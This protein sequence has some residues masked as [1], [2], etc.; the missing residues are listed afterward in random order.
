MKPL[1]RAPA[2][3]VL[4]PLLEVQAFV[5][6]A[7]RLALVGVAHGGVK[8]VG[9]EPPNGPNEPPDVEVGKP[10]PLLLEL[11]PLPELWP[12]SQSVPLLPLLVLV[13]PLLPAVVNGLVLSVFFACVMSTEKEPMPLFACWEIPALPLSELIGLPA[14]DA[15][16]QLVLEL[17]TLTLLEQSEPIYH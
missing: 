17:V 1:F 12:S 11:S 3:L 5:A 9:K 2:L 8:P 7:C 15:K 10:L 4:P 16:I 14:L 13:L 6:L